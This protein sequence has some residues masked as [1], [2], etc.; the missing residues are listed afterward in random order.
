MHPLSE[1]FLVVRTGLS[2][3][4]S[5]LLCRIHFGVLLVGDQEMRNGLP[6][7]AISILKVASLYSRLLVYKDYI[8]HVT[9]FGLVR[10]IISPHLVL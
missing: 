6:V 10:V 3:I 9:H 7:L 4:Q 8:L 5:C 1:V 2:V